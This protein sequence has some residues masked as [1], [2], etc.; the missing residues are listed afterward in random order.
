METDCL[1]ITE[2][3]GANGMHSWCTNISEMGK[4]SN[5]S[6]LQHLSQCKE[7]NNIPTS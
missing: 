6:L 7:E 3:G 5:V 1:K 2:K 4:N